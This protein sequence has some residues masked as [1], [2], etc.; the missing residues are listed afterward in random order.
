MQADLN[1]AITIA[2]RAVAHPA[3]ARIHHRLRTERK[4]GGKGKPDSIVTREPRRFGKSKVRVVV[5]DGHGLPKDRNSNLFF[6]SHGIADFG[7]ARLE[8]DNC[9]SF[10]YASGS[11]LWKIVND[12]DRQWERCMAINSARVQRE[13]EDPEDD[14]PM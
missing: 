7:R 9:K 3:E 5:K 14:V 10:D 13:T 11:G 1:A 6:D 12:R 2:L 8:T 4:K